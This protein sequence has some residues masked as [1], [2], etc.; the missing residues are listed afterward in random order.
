M[1]LQYIIGERD[2]KSGESYFTCF[3]DYL[4]PY[5]L[6][7]HLLQ[8]FSVNHGKIQYFFGMYNRKFLLNIEQKLIAT[9]DVNFKK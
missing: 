2:G 3:A 6:T 8:Q 1:L 4:T 7:L 5:S 9:Y